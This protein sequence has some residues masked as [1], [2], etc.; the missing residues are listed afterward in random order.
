[1]NSDKRY[2]QC[3]LNVDLLFDPLRRFRQTVQ[4]PKGLSKISN[5]F[6]IGG[7]RERALSR[8][9]PTTNGQLVIA[10]FLIVKGQ[11]FGL[12]F[13][14]LRKVML[15][16][17]RDVR[18]DLLPLAPEQRVVDCITQQHMFEGETDERRNA[19]LDR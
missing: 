10:C 18:M 17:C 8:L 7:M 13:G 11:D 19:E 1:M 6:D 16:D 2:S 9:K 14:E 4:Q 12:I 5:R 15:Q 3:Q